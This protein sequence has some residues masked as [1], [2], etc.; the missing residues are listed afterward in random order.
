[1]IFIIFPE[2]NIKQ[3]NHKSFINLK[4]SGSFNALNKFYL[5][6]R[7]HIVLEILEL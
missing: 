3:F 6:L 5:Y 7:C 4:F 2:F 1:M